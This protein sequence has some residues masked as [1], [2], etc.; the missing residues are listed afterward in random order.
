[1]QF[2]EQL[3][4]ARKSNV[5]MFFG[6]TRTIVEGVE[7]LAALNMQ[8][9][10]SQLADIHDAAQ[11]AVSVSEP[12][13]WIA[14]KDGLAAPTAEKVQAWSQQVFDIVAVTQ[15]NL[16][17]CAHAEWDA[18]LRQA[19]ALAED[20][21]KS[22]LAGTGPA[23]AALN[24]AITATNA[25]YETLQKSGEHAVEFTRSNLEAAAAMASSATQRA[26]A[27]QNRATKR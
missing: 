25:L 16:V 14:L 7:K 10:R 13:Q 9:A 12:Q 5:D 15:A 4:A 22:A 1:M 8:A 17:R 18:Q 11:K 3:A 2:P 24:Q 21:A 19:R 20:V 6:V 23:A 27:Q 26:T